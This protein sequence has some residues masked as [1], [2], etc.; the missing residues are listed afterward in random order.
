M[1]DKIHQEE[2]LKAWFLFAGIALSILF[3][4]GYFI[5]IP[6]MI[7]DHIGGRLEDLTTEAEKKLEEIEAVASAV[8][9]ARDEISHQP[10]IVL[11][12]DYA[13]GSVYV[14]NFKG[15]VLSRNNLARIDVIH[16]TQSTFD[17]EPNA[18]G[19]WRSSKTY[20]PGTIFVSAINPGGLAK[21]KI[22]VTTEYGHIL[23]G[24]DN[25]IF[26]YLAEEYTATGTYDIRT[27]YLPGGGENFLE[28]EGIFA[29]AVAEI[30]N[31]G[32]NFDASVFGVPRQTPSEPGYAPYH[33]K[34]NPVVRNTLNGQL[35]GTVMEINKFGNVLT[36]LNVQDSRSLPLTGG[37]F[38]N[39][40]FWREGACVVALQSIEHQ[41][42]YDHVERGKP[43]ILLYSRALEIAI[44]F[45]NF[46]ETHQ[47]DLLDEV[48][49]LP[50]NRAVDATCPS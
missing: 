23:V 49:I 14:S 2:R 20:P 47:I 26:D 37:A 45:G 24:Y 17:E 11:F 46:A 50:D 9:R 29:T 3:G 35:Q 6:D 36:N 27:S 32:E 25:G 1:P 21:D 34:L 31:R 38:Y 8:E 19:F 15:G 28:G 13:F 33:A 4:L 7:K 43:I 41:Q 18:W 22:I 39:V 12:T 30:A 40:E 48:N 5:I 10:Q 42:Y 44:N 16:S